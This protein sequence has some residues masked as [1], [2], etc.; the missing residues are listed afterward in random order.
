MEAFIE[1]YGFG[2]ILVI[3]IGPV[4]F[5]LLKSSLEYGYKAGI[6]VAIGIVVGDAI[7]V[8][9]GL[10][11]LGDK[12]FFE[13]PET[14][15]Y[16]GLAAGSIVIF[17][18]LR[19]LFKP[20]MET[21]GKEIKL[22]ASKYV[23]FFAKGFLVNFVNPFVFGV[24][25]SYITLAKNRFSDYDDQVIFLIA[26]LIGIFSTDALKAI[27]AHKLKIILRTDWLTKIYR[28]IGLILLFSGIGILIRVIFFPIGG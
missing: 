20:P 14:L 12:T 25:F 11:L 6:T 28:I 8:A 13:N 21:E 10:G 22:K 2:L 26:A 19:Y 16:I 15:Y 24:W 1:G 5:T 3:L 7:C 4:F 17:L 9:L 27:F 23:G 18:G